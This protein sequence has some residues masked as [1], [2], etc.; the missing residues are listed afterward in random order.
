[1]KTNG[2]VTKASL[3]VTGMALLGM[4]V[5]TAS[6]FGPGFGLTDEQ[7]GVLQEARELR[8]DGDTDAAQALLEQKGMDRE[9]RRADRE[10]H[11]EATQAAMEAGDYSAFA[12]AVAG[13]QMEEA[14]TEEVFEKMSEAHAL[15]EAGEYDAAR[16]I[17]EELDLPR[18]EKGEGKGHGKGGRHGQGGGCSM[19]QDA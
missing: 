3:V 4:T 12:A 17:M 11:R 10:A 8:M 15:K 1:M 6:A 19:N 13:T 14:L 9:T 2:L 16:E 5:A 18:G 7:K